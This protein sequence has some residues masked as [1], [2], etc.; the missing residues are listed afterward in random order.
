MTKLY[1]GDI[2]GEVIEFDAVTLVDAGA[3]SFVYRAV[4]GGVVFFFE[5]PHDP[6]ANMLLDCAL[7][8]YREQVALIHDEWRASG[9]LIDGGF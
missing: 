8:S 4:V 3:E 7:S 6:D 2:P 9:P 5:T 1:V